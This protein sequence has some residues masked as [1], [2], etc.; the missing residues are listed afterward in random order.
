[1][2]QAELENRRDS[3]RDNILAPTT[4]GRDEILAEIARVTKE[5]A[6]QDIIQSRSKQLA[7][8][9]KDIEKYTQELEKVEEALAALN[10]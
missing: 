7:D 9:E 3:L 2:T 5:G 8:Y 10:K 1:M 6:G 4:A